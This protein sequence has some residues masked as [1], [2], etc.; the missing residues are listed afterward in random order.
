MLLLHVLRAIAS[1]LGSHAK[2]FK[3]TGRPKGQA[4]MELLAACSMANHPADIVLTD[5]F[6]YHI[7]R[8]GGKHLIIWAS[9]PPA[10][11][12]A[13]IADV[14]CQASTSLDCDIESASVSVDP[15]VLTPFQMLRACR[16]SAAVAEQAETLM[17]STPPVEQL[18][19]ALAFCQSLGPGMAEEGGWSVALPPAVASMYA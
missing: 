4:T 14:L 8:L 15:E 11:A 6:T 10:K 9:L 12:L 17:A 2:E 13:Q 16:P 1:Y 19:T 5:S 3:C 18:R 7:L